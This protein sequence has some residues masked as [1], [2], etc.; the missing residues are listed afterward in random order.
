LPSPS[1]ADKEEGAWSKNK[2]V[3]DLDWKRFRQLHYVRQYTRDDV[4]MKERG[5]CWAHFHLGHSLSYL[6]HVTIAIYLFFWSSGK[7]YFKIF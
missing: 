7:N 3:F 4:K 5:A 1:L 6:L 2:T